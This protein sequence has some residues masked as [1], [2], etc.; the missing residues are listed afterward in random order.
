MGRKIIH[1]I[2][3]LV[4]SAKSSRNKNLPLW[5]SSCLNVGQEPAPV[6]VLPPSRKPL[7]PRPR[8]VTILPQDQNHLCSLSS[9]VSAYPPFPLS[10]KHQI[11]QTL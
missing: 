8:F 11:A 2:L 5:P 10:S 1:R 7:W 9:A 6:S 4:S 3:G